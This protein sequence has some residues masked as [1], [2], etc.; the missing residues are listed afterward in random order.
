MHSLSVPA[1]G[2]PK[3]F[4]QNIRVTETQPG[5]EDPYSKF[6]V[7][8]QN[9]RDLMLIYDVTGFIITSSFNLKKGRR[10]KKYLI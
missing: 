4:Q 9:S 7:H 3:T 10:I 5:F 8:L 2:N 1:E 6:G